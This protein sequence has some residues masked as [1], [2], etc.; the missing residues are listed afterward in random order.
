MGSETANS[1]LAWLAIA[2]HAGLFKNTSSPKNACVGGYASEP[3]SVPVKYAS[4]SSTQLI[5]IGFKRSTCT[6]GIT[7]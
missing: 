1:F 3:L 4:K 5:C 7:Y 2:S 6:S